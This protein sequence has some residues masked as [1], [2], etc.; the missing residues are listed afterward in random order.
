MSGSRNMDGLACVRDVT[1]EWHKGRRSPLVPNDGCDDEE[2]RLVME[3]TAQALGADAI[4]L[5]LQEDDTPRSEILKISQCWPDRHN[6]QLLHEQK[7]FL[8]DESAGDDHYWN[9]VTSEGRN[10][11]IMLLP[12]KRT[13]GHRRMV[14]S[15]IFGDVDAKV[16]MAA[17]RV[18]LARRPFAVGYFRL[19]QIVQTR[20]RRENAL[21]AALNSLGVGFVLIDSDTSVVFANA[22]A[23]DILKTADGLKLTNGHIYATNLADT[24]RLRTVLEHVIAQGACE[25]PMLAISRASS[26]PLTLLAL[27]I[28]WDVS[29]IESVAAAIYIIDPAANVSAVL[30]PLCQIYHLTSSE[31]KLACLLA[32]GSNLAECAEKMGVTEQT[33]RSVLKQIFRKTGTTRQAE[34]VTLM[35]LSIVRIH[36]SV[37]I[38][39][40]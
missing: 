15:A 16:R 9:R 17:E 31:K 14:L 21:E 28:A 38:E 6:L 11:D 22:V 5:M 33:A 36:N 4:V 37:R 13:A 19:W 10:L 2:L 35:H 18:Y 25:A 7:A 23:S 32:A 1:R 12:V 26:V 24:V 8:Y 39:G 30:E 3:E 29:E 34:F 20:R 27:P 40:L